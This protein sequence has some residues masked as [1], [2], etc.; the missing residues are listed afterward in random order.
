V[1]EQNCAKCPHLEIMP[2]VNMCVVGCGKTGAMVPAR[3]HNRDDPSGPVSITC[4]RV[5][6]W[7][8]RPE[9]EVEKREDRA[10]ES[11]WTEFEWSAK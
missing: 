7:C 1:K 9:S 5:P 3:A 10:P 11:T 6:T 8:P 4:W 2:V